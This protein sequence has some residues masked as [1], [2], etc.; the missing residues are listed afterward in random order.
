MF[1]FDHNLVPI[2]PRRI[3][4]A[5]DGST[6][7]LE[8]ATIRANNFLSSSMNSMI[9]FLLSKTSTFSSSIFG[10]GGKF[11]TKDLKAGM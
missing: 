8:E 1:Y 4:T 6:Y 10:G 2:E 7:F 5:L 9:F 3:S 11:N